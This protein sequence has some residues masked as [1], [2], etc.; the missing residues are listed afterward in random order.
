MLFASA[1]RS[2]P[3]LGSIP[4]MDAPWVVDT[5]L[6]DIRVVSSFWQFE[7]TMNIRDRFFISLE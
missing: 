6:K 5:Y 3:T 2:F 7:A 4:R 1:L